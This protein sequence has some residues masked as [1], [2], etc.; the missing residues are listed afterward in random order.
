MFIPDPDPGSKRH[1]I[2]IRNTTHHF[3]AEVGRWRQILRVW[4]AGGGGPGVWV[5]APAAAARGPAAPRPRAHTHA[6]HERKQHIMIVAPISI[7]AETPNF[8]WQKT[9]ENF[10]FPVNQGS[11]PHPDTYVWFLASWFR[12]EICKLFIRIR[13]RI[14]LSTSKKNEENLDFYCFVTSLWLFIFEG[15]WKCTFKK[16]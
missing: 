10:I 8:L 6:L 1:R 16:D 11:V 12:I 7:R 15:W 3:W 14:L 13:I 4:S 2:R 5:P 9:N